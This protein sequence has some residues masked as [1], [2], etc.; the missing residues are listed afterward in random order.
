MN[1]RVN[2]RIIAVILLVIGITFQLSA[3]VKTY[4]ITQYGA[5]ADGATSNTS[6]IQKAID[7]ASANGGGMVLVPSGRFVTG[8]IDLK[9]DVELH[10]DK[11]AVLLGS[12]IRADYGEYDASALIVSRHQHHIAITGHGIIDG[13][14][15]ALLKDIYKRLNA[16][17]L[18][19]TEW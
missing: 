7:E 19:D 14:G 11:D 6:A 9:S 8:V 13:Q 2:C 3:Q 15:E 4:N 1:M 17:T 12:I 18:R 10:L 5:V 16:G